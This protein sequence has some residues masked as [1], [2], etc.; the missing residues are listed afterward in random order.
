MSTFEQLL[1][2]DEAAARNARMLVAI[3]GLLDGRLAGFQRSFDGRMDAR[4]TEL[5]DA[6]GARLDGFARSLAHVGGRIDNLEEQVG[7][8]GRRLA[9]IQPPRFVPFP[10]P[11]QL[12][13]IEA[14]SAISPIRARAGR[15]G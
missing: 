6:I 5:Q 4:I 2:S 13:G 12:Y 14:Y 1:V 3:E 7:R 11:R 10:E 8:Q 9:V 15:A